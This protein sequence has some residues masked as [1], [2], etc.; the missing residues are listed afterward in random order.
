MYE[1]PRHDGLKSSIYI[2]TSTHLSTIDLKSDEYDALL[3]FVAG[4]RPQQDAAQDQKYIELET[5]IDELNQAYEAEMKRQDERTTLINQLM[6]S[7][8]MFNDEIEEFAEIIEAKDWDKADC[9]KSAE[10]K[11]RIHNNTNYVAEV[12]AQI[13]TIKLV[14]T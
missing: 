6:K 1:Y 7:K 10:Y 3:A 5:K 12:K 4:Y 8:I 11:Q 14:A 2:S 13:R 9:E